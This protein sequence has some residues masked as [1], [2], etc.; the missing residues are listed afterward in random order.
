M[1]N[2]NQRVA[3]TRDLVKWESHWCPIVDKHRAFV[4]RDA[5]GEFLGP[6]RSWS[7]HIKWADLMTKKDAERELT[8]PNAFIW[9]RGAHIEEVELRVVKAAKPR[10]SKR[11]P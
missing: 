6:G 2:Q 8:I 9:G 5:N 7:A 3:S 1:A 4:I 10:S 11:A